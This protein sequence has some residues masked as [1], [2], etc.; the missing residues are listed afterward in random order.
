MTLQRQGFVVWR[1]QQRGG[2]GEFEED[3]G[4]SDPVGYNHDHYVIRR[5]ESGP[6]AKDMDPLFR[7][8]WIGSFPGSQWLKI[9]PSSTGGAGLIPDRGTKIPH[10]LTAKKP[11]YKTEAIL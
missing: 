6:S 10:G 5:A 7:E 11:K 1:N 9:L 8:S 3:T 4:V 2:E